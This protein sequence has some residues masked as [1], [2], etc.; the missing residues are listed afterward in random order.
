M[1]PGVAESPARVPRTHSQKGS[2]RAMTPALG[3]ALPVPQL[4]TAGL[5]G[6]SRQGGGAGTFP[7]G[8]WYLFLAPPG[9]VFSELSRAGGRLT[10]DAVEALS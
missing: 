1:G 5:G 10:F 7:A 6:G 9:Q 4:L 2:G 3:G 8:R